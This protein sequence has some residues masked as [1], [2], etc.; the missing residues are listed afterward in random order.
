MWIAAECRPPNER[1]CKAAEPHWQ[2]VL[3]CGKGRKLYI[4]T[5]QLKVGINTLSSDL[6]LYSAIPEGSRKETQFSDG[7]G[8]EWHEVSIRGVTIIPQRIESVLLAVWSEFSQI[9]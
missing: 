7:R 9:Q 1:E 4:R 5:G 6:V 3:W 2:R 8:P